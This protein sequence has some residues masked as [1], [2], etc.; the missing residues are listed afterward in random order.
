MLKQKPF[1][2]K[3]PAILCVI[4]TLLPSS[5]RIM[6]AYT[7]AMAS[8]IEKQKALFASSRAERMASMSADEKDLFEK[9]FSDTDSLVSLGRF[10]HRY[11]STS[12][13]SLPPTPPSSPSASSVASSM[14]SSWSSS[15][16]SSVSS[17]TAF[18]LVSDDGN[19]INYILYEDHAYPFETHKVPLYQSQLR[20]NLRDLRAYA[21]WCL[22]RDGVLNDKTMTKFELQ[23]TNLMNYQ[24]D[25]NT[26]FYLVYLPRF[27]ISVKLEFMEGIRETYS[28]RVVDTFEDLLM[29]IAEKH[30]ID[31]RDLRIFYK[32]EVKNHENMFCFEEVMG[33]DGSLKFRIVLDNVEWAYAFHEV[34]VKLRG[35]GGGKRGRGNMEKDD[36]IKN[37]DD[38]VGTA[39]LRINA[40]KGASPAIDNA[41]KGLAELMAY[42]KNENF[43]PPELLTHFDMKELKEALVVSSSG[44]GRADAKC[45]NM[46]KVFFGNCL[47]QLEEVERQTTLMK[48]ALRMAINYYFVVKYSDESGNIQWSSAFNGDVAKA[49]EELVKKD[50]QRNANPPRNG[51]GM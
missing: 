35:R 3:V 8:F 30:D 31:P 48:D 38:E 22:Y 41:K 11:L 17:S 37:L 40:V 46:V 12:A 44:G 16:A 9:V 10:A 7:E 4:L 27:D 33:H 6:E 42:A 39:L 32:K 29:D 13:S 5:L 2:Q 43:Q 45:K 21:I 1:G 34:V 23:T 18:S 49:M 50:N 15:M 19:P 47:A 24:W 26:G 51:L 25:R 28:M 36:Y 20:L 14:A